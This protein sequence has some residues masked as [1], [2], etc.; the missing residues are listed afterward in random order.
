MVHY[1]LEWV[2]GVG[3]HWNCLIG[4]NCQPSD[5]HDSTCKIRRHPSLYVANKNGSRFWSSKIFLTPKCSAMCDSWA[6]LSLSLWY[7][8]DT[9]IWWVICHSSSAGASLGHHL[10]I[11]IPDLW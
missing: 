4:F 9:T 5:I 1:K 7:F 11:N 8:L 2:L 3:C 10:L 6:K